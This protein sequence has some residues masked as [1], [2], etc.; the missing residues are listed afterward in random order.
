[1]P[2]GAV[3]CSEQIPPEFKPFFL[4]LFQ[5]AQGASQQVPTTPY[6]GERLAPVNQQQTASLANMQNVAQGF[7][8]IGQPM[9]DLAQER[10][11]AAVRGLEEVARHIHVALC[12][13][14]AADETPDVY[15]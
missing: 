10:H 7:M 11:Q 5:R 9:M 6:L 4:D 13:A 8:G 1:M 2:E 14:I 12:D 15:F 3:T